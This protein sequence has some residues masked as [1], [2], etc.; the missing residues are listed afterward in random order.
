M[1][2]KLVKS[3]IG[4]KI[5]QTVEKPESDKV[6]LERKNVKAILTNLVDSLLHHQP[7]DPFNYIYN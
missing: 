1:N 6:F 4:Q 5:V 3:N 7:I 2:D